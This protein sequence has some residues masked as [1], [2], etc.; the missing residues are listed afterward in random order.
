[1]KNE[2]E[3]KAQSAADAAFK[4]KSVDTKTKNAALQQMAESLTLNSLAIIK[5]NEKDINNGIAKGLSKS[6]IDRLTLNEKRIIEMA[7][8]LRQIAALP[9]PVGEI[10][11]EI[12]R[13]NGLN[14]QKVR[15][16]IGVIAIVY[17]AR[18]NVTVDAAG[19]CLKAGNAVILRGG[20]D[21]INS[22]TI[23]SMLISEAA[24]KAGLPKGAIEFIASTDREN[25]KL[26]LSQRKYIDCII[27]RGSASLINMVIENSL[28]PVIETGIGNCH[29]YV[30]SSA[31][32]T[33]AREI[34]YNAKVQRPSVCNAIESL[35]VDEKNAAAF[36][37]DMITK[38]KSAGVE[39]RGCAKTKAIAP[40]ITEATEKDWEEEFLDL[41]LAVKVVSG[42]DEAIA[43]ISKY[44]SKH[45]ETIIT[46]DND[47]AT[48]FLNEI[49]AATVYHNAST[50]FTDGFEFGFGA[51][52]GIST[53]KL[54]ARGP[55][56]L[57]EI[58]SY[59]YVVKGIGQ[60]RK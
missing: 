25:V 5:G 10:L 36:L 51:E 3:L 15:V 35:L 24:Q 43:H 4:L 59:K 32:L 14:I 19:L 60:V 16:P 13:P 40:D 7:E 33:M 31:D 42:I 46:S 12:I 1:M 27:P 37:P 22:N 48:R 18:P 26:L 58:T 41:I 39:I 2:I 54:H 28:V 38:L 21:A 9:D 55:M 20:S 8:G 30:E 29:A 17:E 53:Q 52:I 50:R 49:D 11:E 57:K 23:I 56:G 45:S 47:M 6:L 44:G 34:V